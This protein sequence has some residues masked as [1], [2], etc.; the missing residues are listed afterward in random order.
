[1]AILLTGGLGF[2]GSHTAVT[3]LNAGY[4]I[5]IIDNLSNSKLE[6]LRKI[7][8]L[9]KKRVDFIKTSLSN[10]SVIEKALVDYNIDS[11]IH[12]AG[13][14]SVSESVTDPIGYYNNNIVESIILLKTLDKCSV[15][16]LIYSSSATVY[17][18]PKKLPICENHPTN[19]LNPYGRS[20]LFMEEI[21]S[22]TCRSDK[23]WNIISLRYF[24]PVGAHTSGLIG[25]S[26]LGIP[27]N[28][29]PRIINVALGKE[30]L[31]PVYGKD[32][33][34]PDG[35]GIRDYIHVMDL[36]EA[37]MSANTFLLQNPGYEFFN[38]GTG[39]GFSVIEL[40]K[41]VEIASKKEIKYEFY[42]RRSGDVS[43]SF[44]NPSK[45]NKILNWASKRGIED[46]CSSAWNYAKNNVINE[47]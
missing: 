10:S 13:D 17:G 25:E 6:V 35:T 34:T 18:I 33:K 26:P 7:E 2:I 29:M 28:L 8:D 9:T 20:K 5:L 3:L 14:K 47:E 12:F 37:H 40:I 38:I 41:F 23:S 44:A 15:K 11:V 30:Q 27:N 21:F 31:L 24:N 4:E 32:Y 42:P 1:M 36:A 46:M 19:P 39:K 45:A 22:D 43:I 16:N